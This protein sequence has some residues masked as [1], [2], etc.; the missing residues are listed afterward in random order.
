MKILELIERLETIISKYGNLE[1]I[2][3]YLSDDSGLSNVTVL[4]EDGAD[5]EEYGGKVEGVFFE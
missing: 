4:N 2:S 3:G 5:L 1:I